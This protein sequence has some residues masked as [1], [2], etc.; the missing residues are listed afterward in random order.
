MRHGAGDHQRR[1]RFVGGFVARV[2]RR[3]GGDPRCGLSPAA[4]GQP[5]PGGVV[6]VDDRFGQRLHDRLPAHPV[7]Y[8]RP[9]RHA[10]VSRDSAGHHRRHHDCAGVAVAGVCGPGVFA[11][12]GGHRPR[13]FA[14]GPDPV[15][16]LET[17]AQPR[18]ARA[19]RAFVGARCTA[20]GGDWRGAGRVRHHAQQLRRHS[21][22]GAAVA[23]AARR[24]QLRHQP[25]RLRS[26]R[27]CGGQQHGS[28]APVGHQRAGGETVDLRH[29]GRDVRPRR[30]GQHRP[31]RRRF[32][33]SG[34]HGRTRRHRRLLYRRHLDARRLGHGV[35]RAARGVGD[36]QP[37]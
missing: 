30:P 15:L 25:D 35:W 19:G 28:H 13:G 17:T 1:D 5:E 37:G 8:R 26:P 31:P 9:G 27:V 11:A 16:D 12:C 34:Q 23:G 3:A 22:T 14:V 32:T 29:H 7:V 4:A 36:Y 10:G 2:A 6:R 18:T 21:R 20:R 24:V 33:F